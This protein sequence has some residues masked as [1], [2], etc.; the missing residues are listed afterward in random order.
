MAAGVVIDGHCASVESTA[1]EM[2]AFDAGS[3]PGC[4]EVS[5]CVHQSPGFGQPERDELALYQWELTSEHSSAFSALGS[6]F[7]AYLVAL[8]F[9][10]CFA[11]LLL[12]F[13]PQD[14]LLSLQTRHEPDA[15]VSLLK[16]ATLLCLSRMML[17]LGRHF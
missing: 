10:E 6:A 15:A 2:A 1:A 17:W 13:A 7:S 5:L 8:R 9:V 14:T 11:Q 4:G 16:T 12:L 3:N